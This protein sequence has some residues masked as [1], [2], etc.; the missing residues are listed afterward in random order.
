LAVLFGIL[1]AAGSAV[2]PASSPPTA[3]P[4]A[5]L[6]PAVE[7]AL[8]QKTL[9]EFL[10]SHT[11]SDDPSLALRV[12]RIGRKVAAASDRPTVE[13]VFYVVRG[14]EPQAYS[15]PGGTV[16]VTEGVVR[17][18]TDDG[19]LAFTIAHE[20]AHVALRHQ[21]ARLQTRWLVAG[22]PPTT[23]EL[24]DAI[25]GRLD[26]AAEIEAD[27]HGALYALRAGFRYTA[28]YEALKRL[29]HAL[30]QDE[31]AMHPEFEQ[32]IEELRRFEREITRCLAAFNQG[33]RDIE[34]GAYDDAVANLS[35]FVAEFPG[36]I[37]GR[38]NLGA[39]YLGRARARSGTPDGLAEPFPI[40]PDP[41]VTL[42]GGGS[43]AFSDI[44][45][46]AAHFDAALRLDGD[47]PIALAG[48]GIVALR[49]GD[50][51][52]ARRRLARAHELDAENPEILIC[53]GNVEFGAHE[54]AEAGA[55]YTQALALRPRWASALQNL[56]LA[57]E[58]SGQRESAC[59]TWTLEGNDPA[60]ADL[61]AQRRATL[62][63]P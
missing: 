53:A 60:R 14:S 21:V 29:D 12:E 63:C 28:S 7:A 41:G 24:L 52:E 45:Q 51:E 17:L 1:Y 13:A 39:A 26:R 44:A 30:K 54:Y 19:E 10:S 50:F 61:A 31:D 48:S 22:G 18:L 4:I 42:R 23:Q 47:H 46:A 25:L 37:G 36:S 33:V 16:C 56:A 27:R 9:D 49:R 2:K 40:L 55:L 38:V 62:G 43:R 35:L 34:A 5:G 15:F 11:L 20:L 32:R 57:Y 59:A 58:A 6:T 8:G 3:E